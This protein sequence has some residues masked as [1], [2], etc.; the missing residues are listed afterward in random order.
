MLYVKNEAI[1]NFNNPLIIGYDGRIVFHENIPEDSRRFELLGQR[2]DPSLLAL[3]L[4]ICLHEKI[5]ACPKGND[6]QTIHER[7]FELG[8]YLINEINKLED[9]YGKF[10]NIITP[11][12]HFRHNVIVIEP[13]GGITGGGK[14]LYDFLYDLN[15][16]YKNSKRFCTSAQGPYNRRLRICPHF[17]NSIQDIDDIIKLL[18]ESTNKFPELYQY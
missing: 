1:I 5:D 8:T 18:Y 2:N 9:E 4:T 17:Y 11:I 15:G 13:R 12:N 16:T 10:F 7:G 6:P 3:C 14:T